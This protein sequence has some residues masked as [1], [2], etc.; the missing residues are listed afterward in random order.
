MSGWECTWHLH[1]Y[2]KHTNLSLMTLENWMRG[3]LISDFKHLTLCPWASQLEL[4][5]KNWPANEGYTRDV[6]SVPGWIKSPGWGHGNIL[7][8]IHGTIPLWYSC[9]ENPMDRGAWWATVHR[10]AKCGQDWR[11][12]AHTHSRCGHV[13]QLV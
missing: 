9:L 8:N 13:R 4:V 12:L 10:V 6:S 3:H 1:T 2:I 7:G 11:D 5:V